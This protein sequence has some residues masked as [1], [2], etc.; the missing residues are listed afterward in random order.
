[1]RRALTTCLACAGLAL[2]TAAFA[3]PT[4]AIKQ[5]R[6]EYARANYVRAIELLEPQLV[7]KPLMTDEKELREYLHSLDLTEISPLLLE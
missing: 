2:A 3:D 4:V 6:D 1:M 5:A 7:P